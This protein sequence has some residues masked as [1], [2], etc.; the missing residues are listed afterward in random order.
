MGEDF[1]VAGLTVAALFMPLVQPALGPSHI[2]LP[3]PLERFRDSLRRRPGYEW[4]ERTCERF[5][6]PARR[7]AAAA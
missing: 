6:K 5:R 3:E 7:A 4:V 1:T 2:V